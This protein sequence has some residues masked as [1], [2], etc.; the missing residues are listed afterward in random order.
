[1]LNDAMFSKFGKHFNSNQIIFCEFEPGN[2]FYLIQQGRVKITKI[3][4]DREKII[5]ILEAGDIFGEMAILEEQPRSASAI[6]MDELKVLHFN[7]ANFEM[8]LKSYPQLSMKLLVVFS[9]RIFDAK[10]RLM[11]LHMGEANLKVIDTLNMLAEKHPN[12]GQISEISINSKIEEVAHWCA[13][14]EGEVQKILTNLNRAGK[15]ELYHDH[16]VIKNAMDFRRQIQS[17]RKSLKDR[18]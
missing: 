9:K 14:P 5:D 3:I 17:R 2:D 1:M 16:I 12:Y 10:R 4:Q 11:I 13:L 15:I 8:L 7:K 18:H 6:A